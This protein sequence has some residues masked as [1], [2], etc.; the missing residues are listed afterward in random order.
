[1]LLRNRSSRRRD[2][3]ANQEDFKA[4]GWPPGSSVF[5][6]WCFARL[7][8]KA[9]ITTQRRLARRWNPILFEPLATAT[10]P[11][12]ETYC[13]LGFSRNRRARGVV[14]RALRLRRI[15]RTRPAARRPH[16]YLSQTRRS[17]L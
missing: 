12:D 6:R 8:R 7:R 11:A 14:P 17:E 16:S 1:M 13:G 4:G 5:E 10:P 2:S 3:K 9:P 15:H